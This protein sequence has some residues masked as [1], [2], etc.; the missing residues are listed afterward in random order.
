M[1]CEVNSGNELTEAMKWAVVAYS[2][3][4]RNEDTLQL[5]NGAMDILSMKFSVSKR[6]IHRICE[7]YTSQV[8]D[9]MYPDLSHKKK[10]RVGRKSLFNDEISETLIDINR[11]VVRSSRSLVTAY[12]RA[13]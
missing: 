7:E 4:F 3:F 2:N 5:D 10:G 12:Y 8:K 9:V 1:D 6:H 13:N 11:E